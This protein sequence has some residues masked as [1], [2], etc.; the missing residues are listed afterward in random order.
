MVSIRWCGCLHVGTMSEIIWTH[1][2]CT[3]VAC[4]SQCQ[5]QC[6][7]SIHS[8]FYILRFFDF[9]LFYDFHF[10]I[11]SWRAVIRFDRYRWNYAHWNK[12]S[13][14]LKRFHHPKTIQSSRMDGRYMRQKI[15]IGKIVAHLSLILCRHTH[16]MHDVRGNKESHRYRFCVIVEL[17]LPIGRAKQKTHIICTQD[18]Q[19]MGKHKQS[20]FSIDTNGPR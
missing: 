4:Q 19:N 2:L 7:L 12:Q 1:L 5:C 18:N 3:R 16:T 13:K 14:T 9:L 20:M 15:H 6:L 8:N 11:P 17:V 10:G